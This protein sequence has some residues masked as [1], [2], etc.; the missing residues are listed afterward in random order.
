MAQVVSRA[1]AWRLKLSMLCLCCIMALSWSLPA[2]SRGLAA[3]D[4][5]I[6]L[7]TSSSEAKC[8]R[9]T[10]KLKSVAP[11]LRQTCGGSSYSQEA[12]SRGQALLLG[13]FEFASK[14]QDPLTIDCWLTWISCA[15]KAQYTGC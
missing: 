14:H 2:T 7:K 12:G 1:E 13:C 10:T 11:V 4:S 3:E 15:Y 9:A 6:V 8:R 5:V